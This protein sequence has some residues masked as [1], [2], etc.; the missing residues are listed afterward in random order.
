MGPEGTEGEG[1]PVL[2]QEGMWQG[3]EAERAD[4]DPA[5]STPNTAQ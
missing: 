3:K 2:L 4:F 1:M 5:W